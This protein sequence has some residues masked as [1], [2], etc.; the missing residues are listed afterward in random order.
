MQMNGRGADRS[1]TATGSNGRRR[2]QRAP[3]WAASCRRSV[4]VSGAASAGKPQRMAAGAS[5]WRFD[6]MRWRSGGRDGCHH[7]AI[8][9]ARCSLACC[10]CENAADA[11]GDTASGSLSTRCARPERVA[12][13]SGRSEHESELATTTS[14]S[15]DVA[16]AALAAADVL[17]R[18]LTIAEDGPRSVFCTAATAWSDSAGALAGVARAWAFSGAERSPE[19]HARRACCGETSTARHGAAAA[20]QQF[21]ALGRSSALRFC[22]AGPPP[23]PSA[24]S[25]PSR[26]AVHVTHSTSRRRQGR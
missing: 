1:F 7:A 23:L 25:P 14:S 3:P 11:R 13:R 21:T 2:Q 4:Y 20:S 5:A 26:D 10:C 22:M 24:R 18:P 12:G 8:R 9:A 16:S 6:A 15:S 17:A 19:R